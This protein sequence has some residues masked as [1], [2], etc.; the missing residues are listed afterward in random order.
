MNLSSLVLTSY[1]PSMMFTIDSA[2]SPNSSLVV[3]S[4]YSSELVLFDSSFNVIQG[5]FSIGDEC[6]RVI[7]L[8]NDEYAFVVGSYPTTPITNNIISMNTTVSLT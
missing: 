5:G 7:F 4:G 3:V 8:S 1:D 6:D 2:I